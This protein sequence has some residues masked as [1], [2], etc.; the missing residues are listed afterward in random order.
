VTTQAERR[1][2]TRLRDTALTREALE[3]GLPKMRSQWLSSS[4]MVRARLNYGKGEEAISE[5][6]VYC[7]LWAVAEVAGNLIIIMCYVRRTVYVR[8][9]RLQASFPPSRQDSTTVRSSAV[10]PLTRIVPYLLPGRCL[11]P[12]RSSANTYV[13]SALLFCSMGNTKSRKRKAGNS[14]HNVL[15]T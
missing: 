5:E 4:P 12:L 6:N 11:L 3:T 7:V 2:S 8:R 15:R 1:H 9:T 13:V 10:A 14:T